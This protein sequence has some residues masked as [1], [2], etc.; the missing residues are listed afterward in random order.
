MS[1]RD[2]A[3]FVNR[4]APHQAYFN[5]ALFLDAINAPLDAGNPCNGSRYSREGSFTTL[6]SPDLLTLVSEVASRAL[7][8]VWR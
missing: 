1:M 2:F 8:A 5:E 7:K 6:S 3:R 4:D